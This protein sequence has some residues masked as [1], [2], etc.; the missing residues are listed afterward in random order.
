VAGNTSA[1]AVRRRSAAARAVQE[2]ASV[3][4]SSW[5]KKVT[6]PSRRLRRA[7]G[8]TH[9]RPAARHLAQ[10]LHRRA[11]QPV[12]NG[13]DHRSSS[14]RSRTP[15]FQAH[16]ANTWSQRAHMANP[17]ITQQVFP[18]GRGHRTRL[19]VGGVPGR[20]SGQ[21][22]GPEREHLSYIGGWRETPPAPGSKGARTYAVHRTRWRRSSA[23][24][25]A[26]LG[27]VSSSIRNI[28]V[29]IFSEGRGHRRRVSTSPLVLTPATTRCVLGQ[30]HAETGPLRAPN[31]TA[32]GGTLVAPH[33]RATT[34]SRP[35]GEPY[36]ASLPAACG[37]PHLR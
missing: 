21:R 15:T 22:D 23:N 32:V 18:A 12:G 35:T 11:Q 17:V 9:V 3:H 7:A 20:R 30:G 25:S 37:R 13:P 1:V 28:E 33:R 26:Y 16:D 29:A 24:H 27:E 31:V 19:V 34:S 5:A 8:P 6:P 14:T 2:R 10:G 36:R 4:R